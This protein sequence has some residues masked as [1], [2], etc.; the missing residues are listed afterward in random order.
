MKKYLLSIL[1]IFALAA[2]VKRVPEELPPLPLDG[3]T[4][5]EAKIESLLLGGDSRVWPEGA[6]IGICGSLSGTNAKYLLRKAD[7]SLSDAVFYGPQVE[8]KVAAY[9]PWS[10]S[11]SGAWGRMTAVLD[12][13]QAYI[14]DNGPV[15]QFLTYSPLAFGFEKEGKLY[16][17]Y[18]FGMLSIK[19]A[20]EEDL[21]LEGITLGSE[22]LPFAGTGMVTE[23]GMQFG[24]GA[25]HVL[26][27]VFDEPVPVK[28]DAGNLMPFYVVMPP[29]DYPDL[30]IVFHF[31]GEPPFVC[32][33]G[34]IA[35]PR[36]DATSFSMLSMI[37]HSEGPEGFTPVNVAFDEE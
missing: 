13:R 11:Y 37:I 22:S 9:Y 27:L 19:V 20:L 8:G 5:V 35:V 31:T 16:F 28:D 26:D 12:N 4:T 2:C 29:F 18:P 30:T 3:R 25:S 23:E 17:G 32:N 1:G 24:A 34:E 6:A 21:L 36:V 14:P 33:V 10:P 7:A 15:D